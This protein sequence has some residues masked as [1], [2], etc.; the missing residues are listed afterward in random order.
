MVEASLGRLRKL[1]PSVG[2]NKNASV[3]EEDFEDEDN[4]RGETV[5]KKQHDVLV[6]LSIAPQTMLDSRVLTPTKVKRVG[7]HVS[8]TEGYSFKEVE[9][10]HNDVTKSIEW[11]ANK[12]Y[13]RD[14]DVHKLA[15]EVDKYIT[16]YQNMKLDITLLEAEQES[17]EALGDEAERIQRLEDTIARLERDN[18]TL[19]SQ[20]A[21]LTARLAEKT[22]EDTKEETAVPTNGPLTNAEREH[23]N[24][25]EAWAEE[26]NVM[27]DQMETDLAASQE[28][29][30][31]MQEQL[32]A[33][34]EQV[35]NAPDAEALQGE[36][37]SLQAQLTEQQEAY[38]ELHEKFVELEKYSEEADE[39]TKKMEEYTKAL[40]E[41]LE[42]ANQ[43]LAQT[44]ASLEEAL[45]SQSEV[46]EEEAVEEQEVPQQPTTTRFREVP[47]PT[48]YS[49]PEPAKK[50]E[51]MPYRLPA[52]VTLD[53]L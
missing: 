2:Q 24:N 34:T 10:Y 51:E 21:L 16:D 43:E 17:R 1:I 45:A 52:G 19:K 40:E 14:R 4:S 23:L 26:V 47:A 3:P 35:N 33:L 9:D 28:Q 37:A 12:L 13:E 22:P 53:D 5:S 18:N 42:T 44:E 48:Q 50:P 46:Y 15:T 8:E 27:Y 20:N 11:Y 7:F 6:Q 30:R 32:D 38:N 39:Y 36:I 49:E 29:Q 41:Q 31:A 25:L